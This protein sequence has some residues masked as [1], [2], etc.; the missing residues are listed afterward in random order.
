MEILIVLEV[1]PPS[2]FIAQEIHYQAPEL[3]DYLVN[4]PSD[5]SR[6]NIQDIA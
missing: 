4:Y 1:P 3:R 2:R 5:I 6:N